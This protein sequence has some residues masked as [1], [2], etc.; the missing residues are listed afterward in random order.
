VAASGLLAIASW[1]FIE[2]PFRRRQVL[3]PR[4]S[5][6]RAASLSFVGFL[7]AAVALS[8]L[9]GLESRLPPAARRFAAQTRLDPQ[10][11]YQPKVS[12]IPDKLPVFGDRHASP[13]LIIWGDSHAMALFPVVSALCKEKGVTA[14]GAAYQLTPPVLNYT[15]LLS[16]SLKGEA[17]TFNRTV[18][19]YIR[20]RR[21]KAAILA[22]RWD[23]YSRDP[24]FPEAF[25]ET[26]A[27]LRDNNVRVY[28]VCDVAEFPYVVPKALA[29]YSW[30]GWDFSQLGL[31]SHVGATQR[32]SHTRFFAGLAREGVTVLD[33]IPVLQEG[34][35]SVKILP[36]GSQGSFYRDG[37]HLTTYGAL[38]LK[39]LFEPIFNDIVKDNEIHKTSRLA[40]DL[41]PQKETLV[42]IKNRR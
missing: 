37:H 33:P 23:Q 16:G 22:A 6:F 1:R 9:K 13:S 3:A 25:K 39:P 42:S 27:A 32:E 40:Q 11:R 7:C 17:A 31:A 14:S 2:T 38:M 41:S 24:R 18:F 26:V 29:L 28:I 19:E 35:A 30:R 4:A 15:P 20:S 10:Y 8:F 21:L 36:Y 34:T 12:D 5:L